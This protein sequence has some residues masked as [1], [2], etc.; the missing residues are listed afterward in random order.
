MFQIDNRTFRNPQIEF[1]NLMGVEWTVLIYHLQTSLRTRVFSLFCNPGFLRQNLFNALRG[2]VNL[3]LTHI[4]FQRRH[5]TND[6]VKFQ[7]TTL[8][9]RIRKN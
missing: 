4:Q 2:W 7:V 8:A 5:F 9:P 1:L 3:T 6:S